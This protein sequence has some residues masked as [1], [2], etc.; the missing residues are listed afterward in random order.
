MVECPECGADNGRKIMRYCSE[1]GA[2]IDEE[3]IRASWHRDGHWDMSM[4]KIVGRRLSWTDS[5]VVET[6]NATIEI[7]DT[8]NVNIKGDFEIVDIEES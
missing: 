6:E 3:E 4:S 7:T 5:M 1:C 8:G 2:G